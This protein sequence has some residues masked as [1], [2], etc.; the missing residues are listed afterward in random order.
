MNASPPIIFNLVNN[1]QTQEQWTAW[2]LSDTT[3]VATYPGTIEG[4][5]AK[6][7][8][9]S[10]KTGDGTQEIIES[11]AFMN[12]KT[13]LEFEDWSGTSYSNTTFDEDDDGTEVTWDFDA[14]TIPFLMRGM[15]LNGK[16]M[17]RKE[18]NASLDNLAQI[19]E[20]RA[21]NIYD[22]YAIEE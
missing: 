3:M 10:K 12:I 5:G 19:V 22:S 14:V 20:E 9:T 17:M 16:S 18:F 1:I 11:N 6:S 13:A 4:L 15:M 2:S 7:E 8:W 21:N